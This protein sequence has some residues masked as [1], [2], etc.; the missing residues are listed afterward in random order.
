M[1]TDL[2]R[3]FEEF[4]FFEDIHNEPFKKRAYERV[5]ESLESFG[6]DVQELYK[7]EGRKG[8]FNIAGVGE[9]I[10]DN[11]EEF[12]KTGRIKELERYKKKFPVDI[13]SLMAIEGVGPRMI[14]IL[15]EKLKVKNV[16]DLEK[17]ARAGNIRK[18]PHFG[19]KSEQ[20]I[21]KGIEFLKKSSGRIIL[22]FALPD[23]RKLEEK[24]KKHPAVDRVVVAGS[25]RRMKET[26][27]DID[28]LV[29]SKKPEAVMNFF[30]KL[31]EVVRVIGKGPTKASVTLTNG[32]DADMRVVSKESFGSALHYFTGSKDHNVALREIAVKKGL[33]LNEYGLYKKE[34]H[35]AGKDE[36]GVYK[37]LG[38]HFIPPEVRENAGEIEMSRKGYR[39]DDLVDYGDLKGDLQVQT[40]WTD[41]AHSIEEMADAARERGLSYIAITDHTKSLA[42]MGLDEKKMRKEMEEIDKLN[43]KFKS[44]KFKVLKGAEVNI[45]KDGS[46]DMPDS[47]LKEMDV[48]GIAVHSHFSM[49][50]SE[51]TRRI[52]RAMENKHAD[53]LFHPTGRIIQKR[54]PYDV[55]MEEI[56]KAAKR[57]GTILEIDC[58]PSRSDL[59]DEYIRKAVDAEVLLS[60][61]TDAHHKDH[62]A[63]LEYGVGLARRGW[64][65]KSLVINAWPV[66]NMLS[67]LK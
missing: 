37:A 18:L 66:E 44:L 26:I 35:I 25:I 24:I 33:K 7:T 39:F 56:I 50:R 46:L 67:M 63:F 6:E 4:I 59:K 21:L 34:K 2:I 38:L 12:I 52:I 22:G 27:G 15:W 28:I 17:A 47:I 9:G 13:G 61:D 40:S 48:V 20:K 10:A 23:I 16:A 30:V 32:L 5:V 14:K 45:L 36:E 8:L 11:I 65:K 42:M 1:N 58:Y 3:L 51:Q 53:I 29:I 55:N 19:E 49:S 62:F 31:P 54:E 41:G 64:A 57:T 60:I 43:V